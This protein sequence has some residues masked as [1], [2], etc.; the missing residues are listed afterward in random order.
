MRRQS[1]RHNLTMMMD[2]CVARLRTLEGCSVDD[3][4]GSIRFRGRQDLAFNHEY[5]KNEY[6][7]YYV[8]PRGLNKLNYDEFFDT[9]NAVEVEVI[10]NAQEPDFVNLVVNYFEIMFQQIS[11]RLPFSVRGAVS[12]LSPNTTTQ[13]KIMNAAI[14]ILRRFEG[15]DVTYDNGV[16]YK[17]E[18]VFLDEKAMHKCYRIMP[19]GVVMLDSDG[20]NQETIISTSILQKAEEEGKKIKTQEVLDILREKAIEIYAHRVFFF[21]KDVF[22]AADAYATAQKKR[23]M[24]VVSSFLQ[25]HSPK[26]QP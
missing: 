14:E 10:Y 11:A 3:E 1:C 6:Y 5:I 16:C 26:A 25:H 9:D 4:N 15:F 20:T 18:T 7:M 17:G 19:F 22:D 13:K 24:L 23:D 8:C 21:F 2:A 12:S